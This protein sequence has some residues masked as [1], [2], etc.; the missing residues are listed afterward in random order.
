MNVL[1]RPR[2]LHSPIS[3]YEKCG[4]EL[5]GVK[6]RRVSSLCSRLWTQKEKNCSLKPKS[7]RLC[8][9]TV[10]KSKSLMLLFFFFFFWLRRPFKMKTCCMLCFKKCFDWNYKGSRYQLIS[11]EWMTELFQDSLIRV[12]RHIPCHT[13]TD[14]HRHRGTHTKSKSKREAGKEKKESRRALKQTEMAREKERLEGF[15]MFHY[16]ISSRTIS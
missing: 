12:M 4:I 8:L 1:W 13:H 3:H 16:G 10:M 6:K 7:V 9:N 5:N 11:A 15:Q 14:T 2:C